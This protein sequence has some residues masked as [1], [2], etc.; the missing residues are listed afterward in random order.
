MSPEEIKKQLIEDFQMFD[1]WMD[2]YDYLIE[3]GKM[4]PPLDPKYKKEE[5]TIKGC[6]SDV[7]LHAYLK[8]GKIYFEADSGAI[9][10]KGLMSLLIKPY[11]G[12]PPEVIENADMDYVNEIGLKEQLTPTRSNGILAMLKQMN[13]YGKNFRSA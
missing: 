1:D 10:T 7:W 5:Y 12:Q 4:L 9:I 2:R 6:Q 8:D 13:Q 11:D 3:M